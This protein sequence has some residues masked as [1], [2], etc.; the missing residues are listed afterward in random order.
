MYFINW[1]KVLVNENKN[2]NIKKIF[3]IDFESCTK[4]QTKDQMYFFA[5]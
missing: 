5:T 4:R 3:L 2:I 1:K